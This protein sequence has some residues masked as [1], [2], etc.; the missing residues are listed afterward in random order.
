MRAFFAAT[1]GVMALFV[2]DLG[3]GWAQG[4]RLRR[5]GP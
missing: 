5:A 2:V 3:L 4:N 1:V